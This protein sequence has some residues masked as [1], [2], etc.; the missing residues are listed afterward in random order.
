ME[1]PVFEP[2]SPLVKLYKDSEDF[3]DA[4]QRRLTDYDHLP[5]TKS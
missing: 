4:C 3:L 2:R 5:C 1:K